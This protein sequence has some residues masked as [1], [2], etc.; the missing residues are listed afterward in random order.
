MNPLAHLACRLRTGYC[1]EEVRYDDI[2]FREVI[3][4]Q[5]HIPRLDDA[6]TNLILHNALFGH[7]NRHFM[8]QADKS[9]RNLSQHPLSP[10]MT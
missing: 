7:K 5:V 2:A 9:V 6:R 10:A 8:T 4:I 1:C 3:C